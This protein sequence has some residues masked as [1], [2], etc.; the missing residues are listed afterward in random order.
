MFWKRKSKNE[1]KVESEIVETILIEIFQQLA[2]QTSKGNE[3]ELVHKILSKRP[4][5]IRKI[6]WM[7][8]NEFKDNNISLTTQEGWGPHN[9]SFT[10]EPK[11]VDE[12]FKLILK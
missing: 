6:V 4:Y 5:E 10:I 1:I 2:V 7:V 8:I 11:I 9:V 3:T 12:I